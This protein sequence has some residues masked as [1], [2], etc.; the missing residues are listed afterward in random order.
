MPVELS[1][2]Q[3]DDLKA[4]KDLHDNIRQDIERAEAA[5]LDMSAE[6]SQLDQMENLR[7]GLLKVYGGTVRRRKLA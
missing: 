5:G 2:Q 1:Q 7:Q 6:R 4:L 3:Q